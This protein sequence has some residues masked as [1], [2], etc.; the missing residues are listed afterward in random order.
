MKNRFAGS[1]TLNN[2]VDTSGGGDWS[3][4]TVTV[5]FADPEGI[6]TTA[7]T[8]VGDVLF[9]DTGA[10]EPGTVTR[11]LV[12][13]ITPTDMVNMDISATF[14]PT[15]DNTAP[16]LSYCVGGVGLISR[17]TAGCPLTILP[18]WSLYNIPEKVTAAAENYNRIFQLSVMAGV[19]NSAPTSALAQAITDGLINFGNAIGQ[20]TFDLPNIP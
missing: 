11:Y 12:S 19:N 5:A 3:S 20:G 9:F 1:V 2:A 10:F 17:N 13:A 18:A 8:A 16:D 6:F 7:D 4:V 15:N 14:D